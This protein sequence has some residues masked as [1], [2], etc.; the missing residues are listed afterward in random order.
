MH[1]SFT[2]LLSISLS[3]FLMCLVQLW[4]GGVQVVGSSS[5]DEVL[6]AL[7]ELP[8]SSSRDQ[9]RLVPLVAEVIRDSKS[10]SSSFSSSSCSSSYFCLF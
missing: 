3:V 4:G 5:P 10:S 1:L 9:D 2:S 6:T 7:R 8:N